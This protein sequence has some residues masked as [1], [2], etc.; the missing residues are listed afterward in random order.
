MSNVNMLSIVNMLK[1]IQQSMSLL[2][3]F[4]LLFTK[5]KV[6]STDCAAKTSLWN[7]NFFKIK[8]YKFVVYYKFVI[9]NCVCK[10]QSEGKYN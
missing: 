3:I 8:M 6:F 10:M 4:L 1:T 5:G 9:S 7:F 2:S